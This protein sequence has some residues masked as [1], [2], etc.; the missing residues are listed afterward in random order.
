MDDKI[1]LKGTLKLYYRQLSYELRN[2]EVQK[3][4]AKMA[5][6]WIKSPYF[7]N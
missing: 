1:Y 5:E 4:L 2:P 3:R 7:F 6:K